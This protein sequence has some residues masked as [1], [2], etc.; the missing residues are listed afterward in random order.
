M[1]ATTPGGTFKAPAG[2]VKARM[3]RQGFGDC[4]LLAFGGEN[5]LETAD[6]IGFQ[7]VSDDT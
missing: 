7:Y 1:K 3:Y 6:L 4:F 2:G 5:G